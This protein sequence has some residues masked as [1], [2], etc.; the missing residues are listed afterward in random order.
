M[1]KTK[2]IH[3]KNS[4]KYRKHPIGQRLIAGL[5]C[6]CLLLVSLPMKN[7]G[8]LAWAAERKEIVVFSAISQEV[9]LQTVSIGT[10]IEEL[11][12]PETLTAVC[13]PPQ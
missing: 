7:Y 3:G 11:E 6:I 4:R 2:G 9:R 8:G 12:L 5:L 1:K 13:R 10:E